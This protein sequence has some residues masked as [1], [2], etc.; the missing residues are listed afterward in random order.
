MFGDWPD[1]ALVLAAML[2]SGGVIK[3]VDDFLDSDEDLCRGERTLAARLGK[4]T[5]P[6]LAILATLA[7][8]CNLHVALAML[9]CSFAV[10][11]LHPWRY[12]RRGIVWK[13]SEIAVA[14]S[15]SIALTGLLLTVWALATLAMADW[16]DDLADT[17]ADKVTGQRNMVLSIGPVATVIC[18]LA[19]LGVAV[20]FNAFYT[21]LAFIALP[22]IHIIAEWTTRHLWKTTEESDADV[23]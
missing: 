2:L 16:L 10:G 21:L 18:T 12:G 9:L 7:A 11:M 14:V 17:A 19:A 20:L 3:L 15:V 4:S 13:L 6:Y 8:A 22:V 23:Q 1:W 5:L